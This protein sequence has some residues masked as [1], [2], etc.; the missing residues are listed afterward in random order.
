MF[1][2]PSPFCS[3]FSNYVVIIILNVIVIVEVIIA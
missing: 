1:F 2:S 3:T